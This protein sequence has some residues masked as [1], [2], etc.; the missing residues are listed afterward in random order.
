MEPQARAKKTKKPSGKKAT[1]KPRVPMHPI[2]KRYIMSTSL[3]GVGGPVIYMVMPT[4]PTMIAYDKSECRDFTPKDLLD[5][6]PPW[7]GD[8]AADDDEDTD[9]EVIRA[10]PVFDQGQ[11]PIVY[12]HLYR[13][14]GHRADWYITHGLRVPAEPARGMDED[15]LFYGF[16]VD[17]RYCPEGEW[18]HF[19]VN[20]LRPIHLGCCLGIERERGW[21]PIRLSEVQR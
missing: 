6:L 9:P 8:L 18:G 7:P 20:E 1:R 14:T 2:A 4:D 17:A 15:F 16:V 11:D 12:A 5:A 10:R 19:S 3:H 13:S 21:R